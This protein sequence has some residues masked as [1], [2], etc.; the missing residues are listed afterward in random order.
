MRK[1]MFDSNTEWQKWGEFDPLWGVASWHGKRKQ[2]GFPW[3]EDE[4][5]K[6]GEMDW[7]DFV[8]HWSTYGLDTT[9]CLEIGCGAGRMTK[10]LAKTFAATH[11]IDVSAGMLE[12]AR[13]N[14]QASSVEF[15]LTEGVEIPLPDESV[16]AVFSV[17]V[18]QHFDS[19]N[20]ASAY[21]NQVARVMAPN[22]S[23]MIH[24]PIHISSI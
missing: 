3:T 7:Q 9:S 24:L 20:N 4:F 18:F 12:Y 15:H 21:F 8:K 11:A 17:H 16:S 2:E 22:S 13:S 1:L 23:L 10:Q 5:Y 6:L 14:V 19:L